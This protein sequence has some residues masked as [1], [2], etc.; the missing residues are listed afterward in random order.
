MKILAVI[1]ARYDSQRL[2]GKV[3]ALIGNKPMVQWVYEAAVNS[4]VFTKVVVATDSQLVADRVISFGGDVEMT[5]PKH[6]TGTDRVAEVATRYQEFSVVVNVQGDQPFVTSQM[7]AELV[8]PY[9]EGESPEMTT[10]ACPLNQETGYHDPNVVKVLCG[11]KQQALYF[12]RS[13]IPFYRNPI[14]VPVFHH[15]GLYAFRQDFLETYTQLPSTPIEQCEGLEQLR[16]LE[17]GYT[18]RVCQ[19]AKAVVEVNTAEDL[20]KAQHLVLETA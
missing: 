6:S 19:T 8:T 11:Q 9:L 18:I 15:L 2:A 12:S 16:V 13:P 10:L 5:S 20:V 1:P 7:L 4:K 14:E 17:H 3:L